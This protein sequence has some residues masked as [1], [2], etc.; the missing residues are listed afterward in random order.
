LEKNLLYRNLATDN[1]GYYNKFFLADGMAVKWTMHPEAL[2][3]AMRK[4]QPLYTEKAYDF[5]QKLAFVP[6]IPDRSRPRR[7]PD[8]PV[9]IT[10]MRETNMPPLE[11]PLSTRPAFPSVKV[12][13]EKLEESMGHP[14]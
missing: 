13:E 14:M 3:L 1:V 8:I 4:M 9:V 12:R 7:N 11:V 5:L 10:G 6:Y 2:I